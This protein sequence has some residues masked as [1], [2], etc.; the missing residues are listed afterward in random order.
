MCRELDIADNCLL[1]WLVN[2]N[3]QVAITSSAYNQKLQQVEDYDKMYCKSNV[4]VKGNTVVTEMQCSMH[5]LMVHQYMALL[6][7]VVHCAI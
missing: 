6:T 4:R 2:C 3:G 5:M 1:E 7:F